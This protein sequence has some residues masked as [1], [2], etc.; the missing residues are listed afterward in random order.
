MIILNIIPTPYV[1]TMTSFLSFKKFFF[2]VYCN[3]KF[4]LKTSTFE[5]V[6]F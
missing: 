2:K 6:H 4:K 5:G 1:V 3:Q